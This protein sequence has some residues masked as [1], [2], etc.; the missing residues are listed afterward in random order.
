M[1]IKEDVL[2]ALDYGKTAYYKAIQAVP[3]YQTALQRVSQDYKDRSWIDLTTFLP[4]FTTA[5]FEERRTKYQAKYGNTVNIPGFA[6]V[7][8]II[9]KAKISA[10]EMAAHKWAQQRGL[11]SPLTGEQLQ[12]LQYKKFRFLKA[13]S[14]ATPEWMRTIGA[15]GTSLDNVEDALVTI[16]VL[17]RLAVR[18]APRLM[19]R[20]V[21][22]LG[23]VLMGSDILNA[24]NIAAWASFAA[25]GG[26]RNIEGLAEKNPFHTKAAANRAL[27][28]Q[29][30]WP[31][32]GEYLEI[33]Q[34]T[35]QL[36]G[37]GLC[38]GG[39]MG[40]VT[41]TTT[42]VMTYSAQDNYASMP[43]TGNIDELTRW[44]NEGFAS[45]VD[46]FKKGAQEKW[47]QFRDEAYRL[48]AYDT[49]LRTDVYNWAQETQAIAVD[50]IKSI[51][52]KIYGSFA[53]SILGSMIL[54]T[55]KDT[56]LKEDHTKA[57]M[58]LNPAI[59]G[60]IP[61]W[62][63]NDPLSAFKDLR[64]YKFRAPQPK[65]PDTI[66]ILNETSPGWENT[67]KWPHLDK[68][69]ATM[70]EIAYTYAPKIKDSFQTYC[71][72]HSR[73]FEAMVAAQSATDFTRN[74]I[75]AFSD[76][77]QVRIAWD[78]Y[79][80]VALDMM[81]FAYIIPPDTPKEKI[82]ALANYIGAYERETGGSPQI[83]DVAR[84]GDLLGIKWMRSFPTKTFREAA[85][86]FPEWREIQDQMN[87]IFIPD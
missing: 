5:E 65:A 49:K 31:T 6:D 25:R 35:D 77:N 69:Y 26:K 24:V 78:A 79:T 67:V 64:N 57:L 80:A 85:E 45:D 23:W 33:L 19:G 46:N 75:R 20:T 16:A 13:L 81:Q 74:I 84:Q 43:K 39:L 87:E 27:K 73:E 29:R 83:H 54:S 30:T 52:E 36:F 7:I 41:D 12:T 58:M 9:P 28:L 76:D 66:T 48:K 61:W 10:E 37:I 14:S 18:I 50:K 60:L 2:R 55:G 72:N 56:F 15:V 63:E 8:H 71:L 34:T 53:D 51:P 42:K 4:K 38:L 21:P 44:A 70:E 3:S 32:F 40:M 1:S 22:V 82:E 62:I 68:E 86:I 47:Y 11:P 59:Q 17:G